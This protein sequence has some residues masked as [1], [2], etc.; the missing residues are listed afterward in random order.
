MPVDDAEDVEE[1][2]D[3]SSSNG[4]SVNPSL[5]SSSSASLKGAGGGGGK[6]ASFALAKDRCNS[7]MIREGWK[8][9]YGYHRRFDNETKF[10]GVFRCKVKLKDDALSAVGMLVFSESTSVL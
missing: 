5:P 10:F 2:E 6:T 9:D 7:L 4:S 3:E 8:E 1:A